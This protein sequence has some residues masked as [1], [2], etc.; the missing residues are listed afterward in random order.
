MLQEGFSALG[1]GSMSCWANEKF[2]E[3]PKFDLYI[4][5]SIFVLLVVLTKGRLG[6]REVDQ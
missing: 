2:N 3:K 6:H 1:A 5:R 4:R